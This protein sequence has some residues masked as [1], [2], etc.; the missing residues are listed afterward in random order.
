MAVILASPISHHK[1]VRSIQTIGL[2]GAGKIASQLARLA[3]ATG[4]DV[5]LGSSRGPDTLDDLVA[6]PESPRR[7]A[8]RCPTKGGSPRRHRAAEGLP[9][10]SANV[11]GQDPPRVVQHGRD[12]FGR[13][14]REPCLTERG[15]EPIRRE[16]R[17]Q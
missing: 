6:E 5:V 17:E 1:G 3:V 7:N 12:P 14:R 11:R 2:I 4:Y 15:G 13:N 8:R 9:V 10:L 16:E